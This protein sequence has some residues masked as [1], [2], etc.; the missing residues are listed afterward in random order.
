MAGK[1]RWPGI[2]LGRILLALLLVFT[3]ASE[4][5]RI[6]VP[7]PASS[8]MVVE[9]LGHMKLQSAEIMI[10]LDA[11]IDWAPTGD[12][13]FDRELTA[14]KARAQRVTAALEVLRAAVDDYG[15]AAGS[16]KGVS[17]LTGAVVA[18]ASAAVKTYTLQVMRLATSKNDF[19]AAVGGTHSSRNQNQA[20]FRKA[21]SDLRTSIA[22][23]HAAETRI[24]EWVSRRIPY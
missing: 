15:V 3:A 8:K 6:S 20:N 24:S 23:A 17:E 1:V 11:E 18:L 2:P 12:F 19:S 22:A 9:A 21:T 4:I 10:A 13:D 5:A 7:T 14:M 16:E